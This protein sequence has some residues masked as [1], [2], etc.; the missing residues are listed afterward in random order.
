M[1]TC[2]NINPIASFCI[3]TALEEI[4]YFKWWN[5]VVIIIIKSVDRIIECHLILHNEEATV[6][7]PIL[8]MEKTEANNLSNSRSHVY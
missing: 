2:T 6:I 3:A 8:N 4:S 1:I 5:L 7:T